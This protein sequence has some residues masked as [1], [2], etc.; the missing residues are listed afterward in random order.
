[1]EHNRRTFI[2][3]GAAVAFFV[4]I[5]AVAVN[6]NADDGGDSGSGGQ[7]I[8]PTWTAEEVVVDGTELTPV[9]GVEVTAVFTADG[10][11]NGSGGCNNYFGSYEASGGGI[12]F[13]PLG[14]TQMFCAD[15]PGAM[16]L[17]AGYLAALA[18]AERYTVDGGTLTIESP[19]G[20]I[21]YTSG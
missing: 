21:V 7:L 18:G 4:I 9:E 16:D 13:G 14:S 11:V 2:A 20:R 15:P 1:M 8:G 3:L 17:E 12:T 19:A 5:V 6:R 10:E